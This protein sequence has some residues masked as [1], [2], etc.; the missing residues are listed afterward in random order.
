[1]V[2]ELVC[3]GLQ[4]V[5]QGGGKVIEAILQLASGVNIPAFDVSSDKPKPDD[6]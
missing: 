6:I 5:L 4:C 1:M 2:E 3:A